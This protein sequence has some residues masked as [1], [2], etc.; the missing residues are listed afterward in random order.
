[1]VSATSASEADM[2][3]VVGSLV[4]MIVAVRRRWLR[5]GSGRARRVLAA[6]YAPGVTVIEA[7]QRGRS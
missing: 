6:I 4:V 2:D 5:S 1:L 3:M 7:S